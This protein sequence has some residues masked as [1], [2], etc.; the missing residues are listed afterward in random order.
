[1]NYYVV[2]SSQRANGRIIKEGNKYKSERPLGQYACSPEPSRR[3]ATADRLLSFQLGNDSVG[4]H[5]I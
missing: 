3:S 4:R 5:Y 2:S 1:M